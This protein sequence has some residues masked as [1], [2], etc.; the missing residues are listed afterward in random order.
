MHQDDKQIITDAMLS[1]DTRHPWL[2]SAVTHNYA[3][4]QRL[5]SWWL[6]QVL[7]ASQKNISSEDSLP[8][9]QLY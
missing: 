5:V 8:V 7:S 9:N 4:Q 2:L 1:V 6:S 3:D